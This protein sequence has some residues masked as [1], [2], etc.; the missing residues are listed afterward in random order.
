MPSLWSVTSTPKRC[1]LAKATASASSMDVLPCS[2]MDTDVVVVEPAAGLPPR[3]LAERGSVSRWW[4][5]G[6]GHERGSSHGTERIFRY[7]YADAVYVMR[8]AAE[9]RAG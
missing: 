8:L 7:G 2:A 6:S 1:S 9:A 3:A 5:F 4:A